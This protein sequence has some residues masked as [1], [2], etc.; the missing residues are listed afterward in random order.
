MSDL[1]KALALS[2]DKAIH[3]RITDEK[4]SA[5]I[6]EEIKKLPPYKLELVI[7]KEASPIVEGYVRMET[8]KAIRNAIHGINTLLVGPAGCGKTFIARSVANALGVKFG[9]ISC[10]AGMSESHLT[11]YLLPSSTGKFE[12]NPSVFVDIYENGGVFLFD[13]IDAADS[14][15]LLFMNQALANGSFFLPQRMGNPEVKRH[16]DCTIIAAANTYGTGGNLTYAGRERLDEATLDRFR[17]GVIEVGYDKVLEESLV[18]PNLLAWGT[19]IRGKIANASLRRVMSTR[20]LVEATKL[21][22][23][24]VDMKEISDIYFQGWKEDERKKVV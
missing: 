8:T 5:A 24:G 19:S 10:S 3:D 12:Y 16:K 18:D 11:G 21:V 23:S 6:K 20:F 22:R 1:E 15:T 9:S 13:E 2:V 7:N 17:A 4:V 14:N